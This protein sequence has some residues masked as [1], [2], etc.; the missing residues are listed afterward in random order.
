MRLL[1]IRKLVDSTADAAFALSPDGSIV[2]WNRAATSLLGIVEKNALGKTCAEALH[3]TDECGRNCSENCTILERARNHVPMSNYDLQI[4]VVDRR[5]WCNVSV[6]IIDD[7]ALENPYTV[8]IMRPSD[9]QKRFEMLVRDFVV[10]ETSL[11][12]VNMN[13][14]M[15]AKRAP[16]AAIDLTN[17]EKEVL[18][19]LGRGIPTS[20]IAET[21]FISRT[22]ANNHIQHI[23][24]KLSA[25]TRLEAVR[26]AEQAGLI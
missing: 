18:E 2:A 26:R 23:M 13:E 8:H 17:R 4:S 1:E 7:P 12:A 20:E 22:T 6:L 3:G 5:I 9:I 19:M 10:Q 24:K 11:P 21:L 15:S 14:I 16:T 25:H